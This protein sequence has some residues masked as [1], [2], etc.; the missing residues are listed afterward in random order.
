[1]SKQHHFIVCFDEETG[2]FSMDWETTATKF[3]DGNVWNKETQEWESASINDAD[4][5]NYDKQ[6]VLD[7]VLNGWLQKI[8]ETLEEEKFIL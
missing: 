8:N 3:D 4:E 6:E 7:A 1:M 2:E 5:T